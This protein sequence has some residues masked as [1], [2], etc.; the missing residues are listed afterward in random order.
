MR[1][2]RCTGPVPPSRYPQVAV[3]LTVKFNQDIGVFMNAKSLSRY[4]VSSPYAAEVL[5]SNANICLFPTQI[6]KGTTP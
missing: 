5:V 2:G 6:P 3:G 4:T 1:F